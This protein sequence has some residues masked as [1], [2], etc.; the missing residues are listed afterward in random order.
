MLEHDPVTG[1]RQQVVSPGVGPLARGSWQRPF[2]A[3]LGAERH[4]AEIA[5]LEAWNMKAPLSDDETGRLKTARGSLAGCWLAANGRFERIVGRE[6]AELI[7]CDAQGFWWR[8][9]PHD[10][11]HRV[12]WP[13]SPPRFLDGVTMWLTASVRVP[14]FLSLMAW[15]AIA[16]VLVRLILS[17]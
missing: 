10:C 13:W 9:G 17:P 2:R 11:A 4:V 3:Q 7:S 8:Q 1:F 14:R 15:A 6:P 5:R 12:Y 16:Y